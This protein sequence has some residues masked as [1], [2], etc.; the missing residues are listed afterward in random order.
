M[1]LVSR[2]LSKY[3]YSVLLICVKVVAEI[4]DSYELRSPME[5]G[6][7]L[8]EVDDTSLLEMNRSRRRRG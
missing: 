1:E 8:F 6:M 2:E 7:L 3:R 4:L 5:N